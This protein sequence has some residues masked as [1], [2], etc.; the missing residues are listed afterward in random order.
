[1]KKT[2]LLAVL[3]TALFLGAVCDELLA[4]AWRRTGAF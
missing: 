4:E 2:L 1:M 3:A